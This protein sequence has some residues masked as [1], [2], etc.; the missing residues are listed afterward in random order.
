MVCVVI[1]VAQTRQYKNRFSIF[2]FLYFFIFVFFSILVFVF[3]N[4]CIFSSSYSNRTSMRSNDQD[5]VPELTKAQ[6]R[7]DNA[8]YKVFRTRV[9]EQ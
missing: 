5:S 2:R 8:K 1:T 7:A 9:D 3:F 6:C 4:F